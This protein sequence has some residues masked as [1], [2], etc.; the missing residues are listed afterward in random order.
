M[1]PRLLRPTTSLHPDAGDWANRVRANGGT[2]SGS[3]LNAVSRFCRNIDAAGIRDRF[4]RLNLFCGNS[5]GSLNA[6]RT[7]LYRG[8]SRTGTQYGNALEQNVNFVSNDYA[9]TGSGAGLTSASGKYLRTGMS[10]NAMPDDASTHLSVYLSNCTNPGGS[11]YAIG[12][13]NETAET[14]ISPFSTTNFRARVSGCAFFD[15]PYLSSA[16][17][18]LAVSSLNT[19]TGAFGKR[20]NL[21]PVNGGT[22]GLGRGTNDIP[23]CA[24]LAVGAGYIQS[25]AGVFCGY[26]IGRGMSDTQIDTLYSIMQSFQTT[27]GRQV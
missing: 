12:V 24:R 8:P 3:T 27:L 18:L 17:G 14:W 11:V 16:P 2:V 4:Y 1:N 19:S 5:D 20:N 10:M 25:T 23:V 21:S 22:P 13:T 26:S 9:E 6:V 15:T 7:P